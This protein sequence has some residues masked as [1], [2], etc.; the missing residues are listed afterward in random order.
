MYRCQVCG[1]PSK[2]GVKQHRVVTR[3]REKLYTN[4]I[5]DGYKTEYKTS[6]GYE[7]VS[8]ICVCVAC[9]PMP[10]VDLTTAE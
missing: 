8:E 4:K 2:A 7:T 9:V 5:D 3:T 10:K 1:K 6:K